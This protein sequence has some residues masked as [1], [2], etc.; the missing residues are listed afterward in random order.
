[1]TNFLDEQK[2]YYRARAAEYDQWWLRQGRYDQ[3]QVFL[4]QWQAEQRQLF[5]TFDQLGPVQHALELACGTGNWTERLVQIAEKVTA[6]D[7]S[8]E[9][10]AINRAKVDSPR[11]SYR[12]VDLFEW[13]PDHQY[14]L[15]VAGFWLS[16]IPPDHLMPHLRMLRR[17]LKPDG[18]LFLVD[19]QRYTTQ[20][21][22]DQDVNSERYLQKRV[23]NDGSEYV[24]LKRYYAQAELQD[25]LH[26][27]GLPAEV[28][29]TPTFFWMAVI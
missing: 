17:A 16:H 10:I 2:A 25:V 6:L 3:G 13:G 19:G 7:A 18:R 27:A 15:L 22:L 5:A 21:D 9:M 20:Q 1:M 14:D 29:F 4:S 24:I 11:V 23:L 28:I 26:E 12:Q 8:E